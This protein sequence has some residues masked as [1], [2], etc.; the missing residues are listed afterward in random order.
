[1]IRSER[2]G[3]GVHH[4]RTLTVVHEIEVVDGGRVMGR[5]LTLDAKEARRLM[6]YHEEMRALPAR[7]KVVSPQE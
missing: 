4:T 6:A 7:V 2:L 5:Y 3:N 1:M